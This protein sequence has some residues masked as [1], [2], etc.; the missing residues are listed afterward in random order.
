M[1]CRAK[2]ILRVAVIALLLVGCDKIR[3]HV[4]YVSGPS[5]M[6]NV[7]CEINNTDPEFFVEVECDAEN[8]TSYIVRTNNK[9][10]ESTANEDVKILR[11]IIDLYR[12]VDSHSE[13]V[14]RKVYYADINNPTINPTQFDVKAEEY[15]VLVWC[16]YVLADKPEESL[17]YNTDNLCSVLY[18]D[19]EIKNNNDKDA[20]TGMVNVN[21][22]NYNSTLTGVYDIHEH[23]ILERPNGRYKCV[24]TDIDEFME[25]D[26]RCSEITGVISYVQY[27]ASGYSVE[28]QKPNNF[29]PVRTFVTTVSTDD[30]DEEGNLM[31]SYDYV[32][33]NGK[34]TNVKLNMQ[35]YRGRITKVGNMLVKE[36]GTLVD[37]DDIISEW[38]ELS[39]PL[40]R[41]METMIT[42]RLLTT[43]F[44]P[45]GIGIDPG[46]EDEI[47]IPWE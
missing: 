29:D 34:Q 43:S 11:Y 42:G 6:L 40:R 36:D 28:E 8:G 27:V 15:K 13:F 31:L 14:E 41:N 3:I 18:N 44:D 1:W 20:F 25:S 26:Y 38:K 5:L 32:F 30:L 7:S 35:F 16:D 23:L 2:H 46:F 21:L 39:V 9:L 17:Y 4:N 24:T 22:R 33:V 19:I 12:V 37:H 45:G 47:I 10:P